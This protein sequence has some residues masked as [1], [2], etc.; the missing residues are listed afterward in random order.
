[1]EHLLFQ[2]MERNYYYQRQF[3][4]ISQPERFTSLIID[5]MAQ[6]GCR[7]PR[8]TRFEYGGFRLEQKLTGVLVHRSDG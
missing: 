8:K 1:M 7:I 5:G 4:A 2:Q 6:D 3:L